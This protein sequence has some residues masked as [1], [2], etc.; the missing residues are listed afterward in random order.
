[1][2]FQP[3]MFN[4]DLK[5]VVFGIIF[6]NLLQ[7]NKNVA[8]IRQEKTNQSPYEYLTFEDFPPN[9]FIP[10]PMLINFEGKVHPIPLF[11]TLRLLGS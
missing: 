7:E 8:K 11:H 5:K 6:Q 2:D 3:I 4:F 10:S 1:M 9:A